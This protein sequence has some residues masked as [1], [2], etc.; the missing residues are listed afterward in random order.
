MVHK[1]FENKRRFHL[2]VV[3]LL[4]SCSVGQNLGVCVV[5]LDFLQ[6]GFVFF[7]KIRMCKCSDMGNI[8]VFELRINQ[9]L[10]LIQNV[11]SSVRFQFLHWGG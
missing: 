7:L 3:L 4:M 10:L 5:I 2:D 8:Y 9:F 1:F 11:L 6:C